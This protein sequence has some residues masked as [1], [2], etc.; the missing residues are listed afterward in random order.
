MTAVEAHLGQDSFGCSNEAEVAK[1]MEVAESL[2]SGGEKYIGVI[3]SELSQVV[4]PNFTCGFPVFLVN[5]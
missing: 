2:H 1:V 5:I 4:H 3:S